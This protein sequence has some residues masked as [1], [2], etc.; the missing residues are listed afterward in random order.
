ML[1]VLRIKAS[2]SIIQRDVNGPRQIKIPSEDL[3]TRGELICGDSRPILQKDVIGYG[4]PVSKYTHQEKRDVIGSPA[5]Y[6]P[7]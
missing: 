7:K 4:I 2:P 1:L 3:I 6:T 5:H